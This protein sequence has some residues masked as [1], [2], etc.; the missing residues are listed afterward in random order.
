MFRETSYIILSEDYFCLFFLKC[1]FF[2]L[3]ILEQGIRNTLDYSTYDKKLMSTEYLPYL[4]HGVVFVVNYP[5]FNLLRAIK[6]HPISQMKK[7]G[8]KVMCSRSHPTSNALK[9]GIV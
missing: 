9:T 2:I 7:L 8:V 6:S 3:S 5:L 1:L 4:K